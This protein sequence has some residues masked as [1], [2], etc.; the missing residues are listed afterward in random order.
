MPN[1]RSCRA[2][3]CLRRAHSKP[4]HAAID[5]EEISN[6]LPSER[7]FYDCDYYIVKSKPIVRLNLSRY[8][9]SRTEI[10]S[11]SPPSPDSRSMTQRFSWVATFPI[12][13]AWPHD[14][15][16]LC[17]HDHPPKPRSTQ[18]RDRGKVAD[19]RRGLSSRFSSLQ[20][21]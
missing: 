19:R 9:D 5:C 11:T 14:H 16:N 10:A 3:G 21:A 12:P 18:P 13:V 7:P 2:S 8:L 20:G 6:L 4:E 17:T 1:P 15:H